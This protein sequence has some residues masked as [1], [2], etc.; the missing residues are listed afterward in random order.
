MIII[1]LY[2]P[3]VTHESLYTLKNL[4]YYVRL[5]STLSISIIYISTNNI[6]TKNLATVEMCVLLRYFAKNEFKHVQLLRVGI[7]VRLFARETLQPLL[8]YVEV[9]SVVKFSQKIN[10]NDIWTC[11]SEVYH[12]RAVTQLLSKL[13]TEKAI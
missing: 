11:L 9:C 1:P 6:F 10:L 13:K 8:Q 4:T 2:L 12:P 5:L 3:S 7:W